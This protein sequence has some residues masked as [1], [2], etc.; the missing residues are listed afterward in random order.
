MSEK[1]GAVLAPFCAGKAP[2]PSPSL[3]HT[4]TACILGVYMTASTT[5]RVSTGTRDLLRTLSARRKQPAGEIVAELVH[6]ADDDQLLSDAEGSFARIAREPGALAAY[7]A[8][9]DRLADGFD[10]PAPGW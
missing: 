9:T 10:A 8:E 6:G 5:I 4:P 7:H 3:S 1:V 2:R